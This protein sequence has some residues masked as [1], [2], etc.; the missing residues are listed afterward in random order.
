MEKLEKLCCCC[1]K[2]K[3]ELKI[4]IGK[5]EKQYFITLLKKKLLEKVKVQNLSEEK[6]QKFKLKIEQSTL[7]DLCQ[8]FSNEELQRFWQSV[9]GQTAE[10]LKK[11]GKFFKNSF[12]KLFKKKK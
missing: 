10:S 2:N 7:E 5:D 4:K 1:C 11:L 8:S 3:K 6:L 9:Q 12:S